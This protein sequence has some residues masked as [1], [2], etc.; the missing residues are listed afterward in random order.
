MATHTVNHGA[1]GKYLTFS[2][3]AEH[4]GIEITRVQE[5]VGLLPVT[6]VPRLPAVIAGVV[7]LRGRV[8]PVVDLRL[9][10]GL[11]ATEVTERTCII[12]VSTT[13]L[14]GRATVMGAIVD[15]VS[16]V[17]A[18]R[19]D[20]IEPT[21]DFSSEVDVSFIKGV[22]RAED[23]VVLLLDIDKAL[24]DTRM[25]AVEFGAH[26]EIGEQA[27]EAQGAE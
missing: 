15:D 22:G 8:I 18:F 7:N 11:P 4:Y 2:L 19:G 27:V 9:A 3:A 24:S 5:I 14:D 20:A 21:P 26:S 23:R 1:E 17:V 13:R 25:G 12:V 16:D 6:R 10:F